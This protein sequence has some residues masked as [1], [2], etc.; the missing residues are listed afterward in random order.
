M[1]AARIKIYVV[2][3][4]EYSDYRISGVFTNKELAQKFCD[5]FNSGEGGWGDDHGIE[6]YD[7]N[8]HELELT[9]GYKPYFLRMDREGNASDIEQRGSSYGFGADEGSYGFDVRQNLYHHC[10]AKDEQRA[11][12]ITAELKS[13]IINR[14]EWPDE[15]G[16]LPKDKRR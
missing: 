1:S 6:E 15:D 8:P 12:K 4:G 10:L 5:T 7:A 9:Q 16:I 3:C 13:Q 2:T 14:G 11:I